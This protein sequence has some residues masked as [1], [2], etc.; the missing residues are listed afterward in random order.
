MHDVWV[1]NAPIGDGNCW[2]DAECTDS[3]Q[4]CG[5]ALFDLSPLGQGQHDIQR[6]AVNA[7]ISANPQE[8]EQR[9]AC[10]NDRE[11]CS[12]KDHNKPSCDGNEDCRGFTLHS[13]GAF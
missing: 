11:L 9:G 10:W 3:D 12:N 5:Y 1:P 6:I 8:Q 2:T 4:Q 13:G 7:K